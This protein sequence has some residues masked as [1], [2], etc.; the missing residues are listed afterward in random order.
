MEKKYSKADMDNFFEFVNDQLAAE[1]RQGKIGLYGDC[2]VMFAY[3][4]KG[5]ASHIEGAYAPRFAIDMLCH[6]SA[7]SNGWDSSILSD[8]DVPVLTEYLKRENYAFRVI[9]QKSNL[10]ILALK[11]ECELALRLA[12][13]CS[14][15]FV[16]EAQLIKVLK[17][18]SLED[19]F[20]IIHRYVRD[21]MKTSKCY[22]RGAL[23]FETYKA[24]Q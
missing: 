10:R 16:I 1:D 21:D 18:K 23:A 14:S 3:G 6:Q 5:T 11:P 12:R 4:W 13:N 2:A 15:D 17:I 8:K 7:A 22:S 9:T 20:D 19:V 24:G